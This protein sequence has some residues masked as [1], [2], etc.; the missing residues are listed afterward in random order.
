M[1]QL[2][3]QLYLSPMPIALYSTPNPEKPFFHATLVRDPNVTAVQFFKYFAL[4]LQEIELSIHEIFLYRVLSFTKFVTDY[5]YAKSEEEALQK[6]LLQTDS[7]IPKLKDEDLSDSDMYYFELFHLN[8]VKVLVSFMTSIDL[9]A[10]STEQKNE[11]E[12]EGEN[13]SNG[14]AEILGYVGILTDIERAPIELNALMLQNPFCNKND[15][16]QRI[17]KHYTLAGLKQAYK[18]VGSA[19]FLGNPVSLVSN[20]GTGVK[21]FFYEPAMG[22]VESPAAFGKGIAKGTKSLVLKTTYAIFDTASKLTGTVAKVGAKLTMDDDY[23]RE[24]AIRNQTKARHAG[25]GI[26]YGA[27]DFGIGLYKGIT[28][29]VLEPIKGGQQEGALGVVKGIGKGLAGI[30]LKPVVG[31]VDLV[32]RTTEGIKN[33]TT[34][35]DEKSKAPIRPPRYFG[36][37]GL[38]HVFDYERAA[39]QLV[40]RTLSER[41]GRRD[42]YE[43]HVILKDTLVLFSRHHIFKLEQDKLH[44]GFKW[45]IDWKEKLSNI[46]TSI[47]VIPTEATSSDQKPFTGVVFMIDPLQG[48]SRSRRIRSDAKQASAIGKRLNALSVQVKRATNLAQ[49]SKPTSISST[50]INA[51]TSDVSIPSR[52]PPQ[53]ASS[54]TEN[55][56]KPK[57]TSPSASEPENQDL[58]TIKV[59]PKAGQ[60]SALPDWRPEEDDEDDLYGSITRKRRRKAKASETT[61]LLGEAEAEDGGCCSCSCSVM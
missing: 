48:E 26:V 38:V 1:I 52:A 59:N 43:S 57:Q 23:Q 12:E 15:L 61:R 27:R 53:I 35:M 24:R 49:L 60:Y 33:T 58:F 4:Q 10:S 28:G 46:S 20:L 37:D 36:A 8:P 56:N 55:Q 3:N 29:V 22:I 31:A 41:R 2:D 19:D 54:S 45:Q 6:L 47:V 25:E 34:Y 16:M 39:G 51:S 5:L 17:T 18:I 13:S 14:L 7:E 11:D 32:T 42:I 40:L 30:V 44:F 21:D 9:D 50:P